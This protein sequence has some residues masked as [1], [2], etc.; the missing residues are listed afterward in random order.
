MAE[1]I[2]IRG[3]KV[4]NLKNISLNIPKFKLVVMTGVSGS[5]KSSLAFD[6]L[7]AEGQRRYIESLSTYARQFLGQLERPEVESIEGLSPAIAIEQKQLSANPRSTVGTVTEI[8]D[9]L[10][11]LFARVGKP[12][13]PNCGRPV[14]KQTTDQIV[15]AVFKEKPGT[16]LMILAPLVNFKKGNHKEILKEIKNQGFVRVRIDGQIYQ[17]QEAIKLNLA[18]YKN[19]TIEII[20]DRWIVPDKTISPQELKDEKTRITDSVET[21]LKAGNGLIIVG[22]K[23]YSSKFN[24]PYCQISLPEIEPRSFS[25][26][27]P[28]GACPGCHGLGFK[29][30]FDEK[31]IVP[32][33]SLSILQG[34]I[35][36]WAEASH[37]VGRQSWFY[38]LLRELAF[39][40]GFSLETPFKNLAPEIKRTI[41]YGNGNFQ[42]VIPY[43]KKRYFETE[44]LFT[45]EEISKYMIESKCSQCDG[46]R[47]KKEF[48]AVKFENYSIADICAFDITAALNFFEKI[49]YKIDSLSK[50]EREIAKPIISEILKRLE[51]LN[52]VGVGYLT[53]DRRSSTLAGG[54]GQRIN[55]ATQIG[56]GLTGVLYILDEP[57]IGLHQ[58]DQK[59]LIK[60][61]INLRDLKNTVI[62]VE[63]DRQTIEAADWIIDLGPQ[64][65]KN[66]GFITF[67]GTIKDLKKSDTLTGLYMKDKFL[68]FNELKKFKTKNIKR[69]ENKGFI[70]IIGAQENNLKNIDVFIPLGKFVCVTGVSGSG[71]SSLINDILAKAILKTFYQAKESPGKFKKIEGL[72]NID[73]AVVV[74]QSPIG[75]TPRSNPATY[76]GIFNMIRDIFAATNEARARGY[77]AGRFSFNTLEGQCEACAGQGQLKV[78]MQFLPDIYVVC[79]ACKGKRYKREI[80]EVLYKEKNIADI[81]N[82]TV[83]EARDFFKNI[84]RLKKRLDILYE[85]GLDYL[86]LGQSAPSLSG[87]EAQ[88]IKLAK[89]L[90]SYIGHHTLYI[91]D[92]PTTGLHFEDIKKLLIILFKLVAQGNTVLV[93]EHNLD[94]IA[95]SDWIIDLGPEGGKEGGEVVICGTPEKVAL[96]KKGYTAKFLKEYFS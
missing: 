50:S 25:F 84:P 15:E 58:R 48:L 51:F 71:K 62:V 46:K 65:G 31:L 57:S 11:L 95:C 66:G 47:L 90:T 79:D 82:M 19:H 96:S 53:L 21:A 49:N 4:H 63:H 33:D 16:K 86:T 42:G 1:F 74:D 75:R 94:V 45:K 92:E 68:I 20:V 59:R 12:H 81:L 43:L 14:I 29:L 28:Q 30:E 61:L 39:Q 6:T 55:L 32:D 73:R 13:C 41:L 17:T 22:E 40:L 27:S 56:S 69:K 23:L 18:R 64:G 8:Y 78:E 93:I 91:L 35:K 10:R 34:A 70:S 38:Y 7:Y 80:L 37:R 2:K 44:S 5:G 9:Y 3:A 26:N 76:T 54:E 88:R 87:G 83:E 89:E 77:R 72:E 60:T 24:C 52:Q 67:E 36:P 85:I